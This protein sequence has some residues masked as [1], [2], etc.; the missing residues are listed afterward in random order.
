[1]PIRIDLTRRRL[2]AGLM[3]GAAISALAGPAAALDVSAARTLVNHVVDAVNQIINSGESE[4]KMFADFEKVFATYA[5][6][7]IIARSSLGIAARSASPAQMKAYT[8]AF[9]GYI[10]RKY[11]RRFREFIGGKITVTGAKPLN[12]FYEVL[13]TAKLRGQQPFD[14]RW[15]VSDKSGRFLF[16]NM[17]IDGVNMLATERTEIGSML[18]QE[19]GNIEKLIAKLKVSG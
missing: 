8:E 15:W 7:P 19:H 10:S 18:D 9:Q 12:S 17:I 1:M 4:N 11:G 2:I 14:L 5:D 3:G 6:V 16:F 13:S